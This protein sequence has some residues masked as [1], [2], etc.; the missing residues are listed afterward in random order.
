MITEKIVMQTE[1]IASEDGKHTYEIK[2][3][4]DDKGMKGLVL[5][6]YPTLSIGRCGE[7][8]L[9]TMHLLNHAKDFGWGSVRII[10]LYS[11]V[12][13]GKPK[14]SELFYDEE[15]IAHIEEIL[16]SKDI[17][18]YDIVIATG[19]SLAKHSKTIEAKIDI[20]TM[21][22]EKGLEPQ[23]KYITVDLEDKETMVGVHP[24]YLGLHHGKSVWRLEKFPIHDELKILEETLKLKEKYTE[25]KSKGILNSENTV[26]VQDSDTVSKEEKQDSV[27]KGGNKGNVPK[28]KKQ[29]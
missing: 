29:A 18:D 21:L 11:L 27:T 7:M 20:L 26:S 5:E 12:C 14:T 8:D 22:L 24:L 6:L 2:R 16:E 10:N 9:S 25:L 4:W 15:N 13:S 1:I 3:S 17:S 28:N 19:N 23:I